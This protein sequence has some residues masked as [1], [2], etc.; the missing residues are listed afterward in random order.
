MFMRIFA[1]AIIFLAAAT[2]IARADTSEATRNATR[3]QVRALLATAG[4]RSDVNIP[5]RQSTQNPYNF[6]GSATTGL[7]NSDS[8]EV[9][10]SVTKS[11]TIG[12]RVYPHY[13]GGYI[14]IGK[15]K[16]SVG[17]MR[18]LLYFSDQNFLFWGA[19]DTADVFCGYTVTL[20]SGFPSEAIVVV[21][22]SIKNTDG[23]VGQLAPF[24]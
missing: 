5:F 15:A 3:E 23:F 8:I 18:K 1:A 7:T 20:E 24:I 16:D 9:V 14:N 13:H 17:L 10:V 4:Q 12:F 2:P 6:V 21:L 11:D 22:R 19:D